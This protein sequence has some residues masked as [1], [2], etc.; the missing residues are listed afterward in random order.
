MS[1][2][3][4]NRTKIKENAFC[5]RSQGFRESYAMTLFSHYTSLD[6]AVTSQLQT[7]MKDYFISQDLLTWRRR[8][9]GYHKY[10]VFLIMATFW[11][12]SYPMKERFCRTLPCTHCTHLLMLCYDV[13]EFS[14]P[15]FE[16]SHCQRN[17]PETVE[18]KQNK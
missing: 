17:R 2:G 18:I 7:V 6:E 3:G 12:V 1:F 8:C 10:L 14:S 16:L 9:P 4:L 15:S 11:S 13:S 5:C